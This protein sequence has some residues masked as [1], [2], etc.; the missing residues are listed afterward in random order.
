MAKFKIIKLKL[1][2]E[3]K[4][5]IYPLSISNV[6]ADEGE[7]IILLPSHHD[8]EEITL[9]GYEQAY[10][11]AHEHWHD[12]HHPA[13]GSEWIEESYDKTFANICLPSSIKKLIIPKNIV[14]F[15]SYSLEYNRKYKLEVEKDHPVYYIN[16]KGSLAKK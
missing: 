8:G 13:Q 11:P 3:K 10:T 6:T 4:G 14:D 16:E 2:T 9:F 5:Y 1:G 12:W 15:C 7:E